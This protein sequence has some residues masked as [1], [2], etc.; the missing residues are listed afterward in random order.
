MS[1]ACHVSLLALVTLCACKDIRDL[2]RRL[3]NEAEDAVAGPAAKA[4]A[5]ELC[6][7]AK[8]GATDYATLMEKWD[9]STPY[10]DN[11]KGAVESVAKSQRYDMVAHAGG[12]GWSCPELEPALE[13]GT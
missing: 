4:E 8:G 7:L 13:S 6:E 2:K 10:G 1:T 3:L 9:P 12:P 11:M 5:D